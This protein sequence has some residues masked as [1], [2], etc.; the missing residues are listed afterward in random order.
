[1][2]V[3][4]QWVSFGIAVIGAISGLYALWL[5]HKR[6]KITLNH[7]KERQEE[8][9]KAS[10]KIS[11]T[12]QPG[13][14]RMQDKFILTNTGQAIANNVSVEFYS[15][16]RGTDGK[17]KVNPLIAEVPKTI[18]PGQEVNIIMLLHA[19]AMPPFEVRIYWDDEFEQ[20]NIKTEIL[21]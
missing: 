6:T 20:G 7:E 1:M 13:R 12:K 21:N 5:N 8:K 16:R 2:P 18:N 11:I 10:F 19:G 14:T 17:Q 15:D 9:K 3:W 4:V